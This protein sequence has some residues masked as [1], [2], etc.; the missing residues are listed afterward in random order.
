MLPFASAGR[1]GMGM[2]CQ[3]WRASCLQ[4]VMGWD[5]AAASLKGNPRQG[6]AQDRMGTSEAWALRIRC[7]LVCSP[8]YKGGAVADDWLMSSGTKSSIPMHLHILS[9]ACSLLMCSWT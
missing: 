8:R 2:E 7:G 5:S 9:C 6:M 1:E 4:L 3:Y